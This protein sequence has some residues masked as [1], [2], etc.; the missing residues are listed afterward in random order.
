MKKALIGA[1]VLL[2]LLLGGFFVLLS[3]ASPQNAPQ[4]VK[5][6]ELPDTYEK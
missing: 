4:E 3:K 5:I 2:I 1:S 6:I